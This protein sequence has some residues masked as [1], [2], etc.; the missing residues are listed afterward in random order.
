[1]LNPIT[2]GKRLIPL[3]Q[4]AF[5]ERY[6]PRETGGIQSSRTFHSRLVLTNRDSTLLE[7]TP[8][9]FANQYGFRFIEAD[10]LCINRLVYYAVETFSSDEDFSPSKAYLTRLRWKDNGAEHSKLLVTPPEAVLAA[11]TENS[12]K[13]E[14]P[15]QRAKTQRRRSPRNDKQDLSQS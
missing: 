10:D 7:E 5:V 1:M 3:E 15:P 11:I 9:Q 6:E 13:Q 2:V 8:Q 14:L 4:V 12:P